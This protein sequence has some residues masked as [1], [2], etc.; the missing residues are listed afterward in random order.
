VSDLAVEAVYCP[1]CGLRLPPPGAAAEGSASTDPVESSFSSTIVRSYANAMYR[2]GVRYEV[3]HNESE[4][5]RCFGKASQL[6]NAAAAVCLLD[7][8]LSKKLGPP[9]DPPSPS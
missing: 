4:A 2:L 7:I 6:G 9:A 8:T 5:A 3:R 1:R